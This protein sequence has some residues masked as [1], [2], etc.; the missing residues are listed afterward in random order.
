M[1]LHPEELRVAGTLRELAVRNETVSEIV[2]GTLG[3]RTGRFEDVL[4]GREGIS[5]RDLFEL[6]GELETTPSDFFGRLYGLGVEAEPGGDTRFV[7]SKR[8]VLDAMRRR[9]L[10]K[11]ERGEA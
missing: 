6:L 8:A 10:W 4:D 11:K 1:T 2:E 3:W 7:E 5:L 9:R